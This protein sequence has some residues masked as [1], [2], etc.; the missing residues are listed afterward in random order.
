M[1]REAWAEA[2]SQQRASRVCR[3]DVTDCLFCC[4]AFHLCLLL[5]CAL[6]A[7]QTSAPSDLFHFAQGV[8]EVNVHFLFSGVT[9]V[10]TGW[11]AHG[12][13]SIVDFLLDF[14]VHT[15]DCSGWMSFLIL[16]K[17]RHLRNSR[18]WFHTN[19]SAHEQP[20]TYA[21]QKD[22]LEG[23]PL[24][25]IVIWILWWGRPRHSC[26]RLR[27]LLRKGDPGVKTG[28]GGSLYFTLGA[29]L[30]GDLTPHW[31]TIWV[32]L[33]VLEVGTGVPPTN[34]LSESRLCGGRFLGGQALLS[35]TVLERACPPFQGAAVM[36][37][38]PGCVQ[39]LLG[40]LPSVS[41]ASCQDMSSSDLFLSDT[42]QLSCHCAGPI[43]R[44][45]GQKETTLGQRTHSPPR[46]QTAEGAGREADSLIQK[47]AGTSSNSGSGV[48]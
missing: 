3:D 29:G 19:N 37:F 44:I 33:F 18:K 31:E 20:R 28:V 23:C 22:L 12:P 8:Q 17:F 41:P 10:S 38:L 5:A 39:A 26:H 21:C 6:P 30:H 36:H 43:P 40:C 46:T 27:P 25:L 24:V 15:L 11:K 47:P 35:G 42:W 13:V 34:V 7:A 14:Y 2:W 32:P 16:R 48:K 4:L 9:V 1:D 45:V